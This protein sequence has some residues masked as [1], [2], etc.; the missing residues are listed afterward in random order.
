MPPQSRLLHAR[1]LLDRDGIEPA[2]RAHLTSD[3]LPGCTDRIGSSHSGLAH[4]HEHDDPG[5]RGQRGDDANGE[6][7][8]GTIGEDAG[9]DGSER[10][11][12]IPPEPVDADRRAAP[13][14]WA[15]SA[16]AASSVG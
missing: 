6:G 11:A 10:E 1:S 16:T 9:N 7:H 13:R 15:T 5:E 2:R 12:E 3:A 4:P 14:G 8:A